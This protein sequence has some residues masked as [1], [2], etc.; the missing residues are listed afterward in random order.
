MCIEKLIDFRIPL[1][2]AQY[3][4]SEFGIMHF[5]AQ[6]LQSNIDETTIA[7]GFSH[8]ANFSLPAPA[9]ATSQPIVSRRLSHD[10]APMRSNAWS[11]LQSIPETPR[12]S[13]MTGYYMDGGALVSDFGSLYANQMYQAPTFQLPTE[14]KRSFEA[15][16]ETS[17]SSVVGGDRRLS[18]P[19]MRRASNV[20][21]SQFS[22]ALPNTQHDAELE[23]FLETTSNVN[24]LNANANDLTTF[25][26]SMA[27]VSDL[28]LVAPDANANVTA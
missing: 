11:V 21:L 17:S 27:K 13:T 15:M 6:I 5:L 26:A 25:W 7:D 18:H 24:N 22:T 10:S 14:R 3:L 1:A 2:R 16:S 19:S 12:R 28:S 20:S 23:A 4:A 9:V 8:S